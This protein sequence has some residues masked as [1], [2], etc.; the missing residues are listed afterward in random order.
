MDDKKRQVTTE[1]VVIMD[2]AIVCG[3]VTLGK[4]CSV[5]FNA[6][7]RGDVDKVI[8]G[9]D[10]NIQECSV[11]HEDTGCP[12]TIGKGVTIGHGCIVHGCTVGDYTTI[13]MGSVV[14]SGAKIGKECMIGAGSLVTGN[15]EVPDG[16]MAFGNPAKPVRR[17]REDEI[18]DLHG[19]SVH[20]KERRELYR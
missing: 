17:L 12:L 1:D 9:E 14:L 10:T 7:V 20:Y 6:V 16:W 5:W 11:L 18:K 2:G 4:G 8:I 19:T 13:G 15:T 3:D